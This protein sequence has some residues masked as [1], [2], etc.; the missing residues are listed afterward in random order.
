M[1]KVIGT[2]DYCWLGRDYLESAGVSRPPVYSSPVLV[3]VNG[4]GILDVVVAAGSSVRAF[5]GIDGSV[6]FDYTD[7]TGAEIYRT[8][9]AVGHLTSTDTVQLAFAGEELDT[10][11]VMGRKAG[12]AA[13]V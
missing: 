9:P 10:N 8:T 7:N 3:D 13:R 1:G 5:S 2:F 12:G 4:D 11:S 6:V